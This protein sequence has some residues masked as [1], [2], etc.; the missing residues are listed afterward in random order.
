MR[1]AGRVGVLFRIPA[2]PAAI[3]DNHM[4]ELQAFGAVRGQKQQAVLPATGLPSPLRQP[5]EEKDVAPAPG[6][7]IEIGARVSF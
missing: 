6:R 5:F 4:V 7:T 3:Q 2:L 1:P